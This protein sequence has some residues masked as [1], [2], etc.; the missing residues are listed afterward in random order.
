[1]KYAGILT[2]EMNLAD[3]HDH[4]TGQNKYTTTR[5]YSP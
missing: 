5:I 3:R 2:K 1:M 4:H